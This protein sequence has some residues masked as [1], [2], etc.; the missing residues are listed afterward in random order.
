VSYSRS[1][2]IEFTVSD[3]LGYPG[4]ER[5]KGTDNPGYPGCAAPL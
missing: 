4:C 5:P 2:A 3:V 1:A